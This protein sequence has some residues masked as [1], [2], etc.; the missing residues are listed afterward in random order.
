MG[1]WIPTPGACRRWRNYHK[2]TVP[3]LC[4]RTRVRG[5]KQVSERTVRKLESKDPQKY[6]QDG[7]IRALA[8]AFSSDGVLC[9][10]QFLGTWQSDD[11]T[12]ERRN[13][14]LIDPTLAPAAPRRPRATPVPKMRTRGV[15]AAINDAE[16]T[17]LE[18]QRRLTANAEI[19]RTIA[20][21]A[22]TVAVRNARHP[23]VG[24][25]WLKEFE[26]SYAEYEG[27]TFAVAGQVLDTRPIPPRAVGILNAESGRGAAYF[28]VGRIARGTDAD[29]T[30]H[31]VEVYPTVFAPR[32]E[33]GKQLVTAH[34]EKRLVTVLA[35]LVVAERKVGST[36]ED[37]WEGFIWYEIG[38][39]NPRPY[40]LVVDE[41]MVGDIFPRAVRVGEKRPAILAPGGIPVD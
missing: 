25:D 30:T 6:L 22:M 2:L 17:A 1:S 23:L 14:E 36:R 29:G 7:I 13:E 9:D 4:D 5:R 21:H 10:P 32:G 41:V 15:P 26:T 33:H 35:R 11:G 16:P 39:P 27:R 24:L 28:K 31:Q 18:V 40:A 8:K 12:L 19:E 38:R 37:T 20:L 3:K 34:K